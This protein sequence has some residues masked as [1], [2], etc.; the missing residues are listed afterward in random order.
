MYLVLTQNEV[1]P[2]GS[3]VPN[4][5]ASS[6]DYR[7]GFN[8]KEKDDE[9]KGEGNSMDY[10]NRLYDTRNGRFFSRDPLEGKYAMFSPYSAFAN[11]PI[12]YVDKDGNE[13][14]IYVVNVPDGKG[15]KSMSNKEL[16]KRIDKANS[17]LK[18]KAENGGYELKT[19]YIL[20]NP[21][22]YSIAGIKKGPLN[23]RFLDKTD[24]VILIGEAENVKNYDL[25]NKIT[26][27]DES[28]NASGSKGWQPLVY[29]D[30]GGVIIN[31]ENTISGSKRGGQIDTETTN[32]DEQVYLMLHSSGHMSKTP[33]NW[34]DHIN[35]GPNIMQ[36]GNAK[37]DYLR[38]NPANR[39]KDLWSSKLELN[40]AF[41]KRMITNFG[42]KPASDNYDKNREKSKNQVGPVKEDGTF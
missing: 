11:N 29:P 7:Y 37:G 9:V 6:E 3:L 35:N 18:S 26:G 31:P 10:G 38:S 28:H 15:N 5:H 14:I 39:V 16:Q 24:G 36:D 12:F 32:F 8:N 33:L 17:I 25:K 41:R 4:R 27:F 30:T 2:F 42:D 21:D 13:N 19:R 22:S 34:D 23:R 20:Y 40:S 1:T